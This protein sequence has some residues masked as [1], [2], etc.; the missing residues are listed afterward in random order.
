MRGKLLKNRFLILCTIL[1]LIGYTQ[2]NQGDCEGSIVICGDTSVDVI[3]SSGDILDFNDPDNSLGCHLTDEASSTWLY[4]RFSDTMPINSILEFIISPYEG[5]EVDYDFAIFAADTPCDSLGEPVRCS[6]SWAFANSGCGFCPITGLGMGETDLSEDPF[7]NGF[8]APLEVQPGQ[9][10]YLYINEFYDAGSGSMSNGFDI[11]FGGS[12]ADYFDCG[13][14]PNCDEVVVNAGA[15]ATVCSGDVP[16]QLIGTA[17][18]TTGFETFTW[19]GTNGEEAFLDDPNIPQP[20]ITF[21]AGFSGTITYILEVALGDCIHLDTIELTVLETPV[22]QAPADTTF[23]QGDSVTLNAGAGF[24]SYTWSTGSP[25]SSITVDSEGTYYITV[26]GAGGNCTI[27]DS[28]IVS[29]VPPPSP[30]ISGPTELCPGDTI[31]LDGGGGYAQY[32]WNG[33]P[34][35]QTLEVNAPGTYTLEVTDSTGCTGQTSVD[36]TFLPQPSVTISGPVG[37][38]PGDDGLL[39]AGAGYATYMWSNDSTTQ[40]IEI[41]APG[42]YSVT[43]SNSSGCTDV[44]SIEVEAYQNPNPEIIGDT[45]LCFGA[46]ALLNSA[47]AHDTYFWSTNSDAPVILID[48]GGTYTLTV[49][50]A[51]GCLGSDTIDIIYNDSLALDINVLQNETLCTGD[52]IFLQASTGFSSYL[53]EDGTVGPILPVTSGGTYTVTVTDEVGCTAVDSISINENPLPDPALNGPGGLC[54]GGNDTLEVALFDQ[55]IWQ[56]GS[57]E[58]QLPI[59]MPGTYTVTVTDGNGCSTT[60]TLEVIAYT[61]PDPMIS[62][63][64]SLCEGTSTLLTLVQPYPAYNWSTSDAGPAILIN[65]AGD[66]S[67]TV[68]NAEGC[69]AADTI[70]V[71]EIPSPSLDLAEE[72]FFCLGDSLSIGPS[73]NYA[74]YNWNT[75]DTT[76]NITINN[77]GIYSLTVTSVNGCAAIDSIS[78]IAN[79]LPDAGLEAQYGFCAGE[80]VTIDANPGLNAYEWSEPNVGESL[81]VNTSGT[82]SLT[83]TDANGCMSVDTF[84]VVENALPLPAID[85]DSTLCLG[86]T[87]LLSPGTGFAAYEWQD[88]SNNPEFEVT[89]AGTYSVTA[90]DANGCSGADSITV[91]TLDLPELAVDTLRSFCENDSLTLS[92]DPGY[93]DYDWSNGSNLPDITIFD[94]GQYEVTVTDDN[95][96]QGTAIIDVT[97]NTLPNPTLDGALYFCF[98]DSTTI[99]I[100]G[101]DIADYEWSTGAMSDTETFSQAGLYTV[102]VTDTNGCENLLDVQIDAQPEIIP[103]VDGTALICEG[104]T[105]TLSTDAGFA[106]YNWSTGAN[107]NN[108]PADT[109]GTYTVTVTDGLGCTGQGSFTLS[110]QPLPETMLSDSAYLCEDGISTLSANPGIASYLWN[111]SDTTSTIEVDQSGIYILTA[112][113]SVG[114]SRVD[115][116][117]VADID[118]PAPFIDG[119]LSICPGDTNQ[120]AVE[121]VY[122][123]YAWSTA[124]TASTIDVT[125]A[126]FYQVSVTSVGGCVATSNIFVVSADSVEVEIAGAN[127][128]CQGDTIT[129]TTDNYISYEWSGG[130]IDPALQV[131]STG[132]YSL[133]VTNF[134]GCTASDTVVVNALSLPNPG[135]PDTLG[136]C[137]NESITISGQGGFASYQ[138]QDNSQADSLVAS[139]GG[140]YSLTVTDNNGCEGT[141]STLAYVQ[142]APTPNI[143]GN[144]TFCPEDSITLEVDSQWPNISWSTG[145]TL[146]A[147]TITQQDIYTVTVMDELGCTG[148]AS[149]QV[150]TFAVTAPAIMA[151]AGLCP[152]TNVILEGEAGYVSYEWNTGDNGPQISVDSAGWY[153]L[154]AEDANGC[155]STASWEIIAYPAPQVE[156]LGADSICQGEIADFSASNNFSDYE[157]STSEQSANIE[158]SVAGTYALTVT[159]DNNCQ[160]SDTIALTVVSLPE[161]EISGQNEICEGDITTLSTTEP[162][163]NYTWSGGSSAPTLEAD[164]A[165]TY[166]LTVANAFGCLGSNTFYLSILPLPEPEIIGP[167][168]L[169]EGSM[170]ELEANMMFDSLWWST[171]ETTLGIEIDTAGSYVLYAQTAAGCVASDTVLISTLTQPEVNIQGDTLICDGEVTELE[172]S[173]DGAALEW[174]TGSDAATIEV[175]T[176]GTITVTATAANGCTATASVDV[177]VSSLPNIDA[178]EDKAL[179]CNLSEVTIGPDGAPQPHMLYE[180]EGPGID[181]NNRLDIQPVVDLEGLYSLIATDTITG[182]IALPDTVLVEDLSYEP[183]AIISL[184][185]TLDCSTPT[186]TL[187]GNGST[188]GPNIVYQWYGPDNMPISSANGLEATAESAGQYTLIVADTLLGCQ[189]DAMQ[190]VESNFDYP[191]VNIAPA[192]EL[193]C[194]V[195]SVILSATASAPSG[196]L[197]LQWLDEVPLP[198]PGATETSYETQDAGWFYLLA[199]DLATGCQSIDSVL[200]LENIEVPTAEAGDD[201]EIDCLSNSAVLDGT[202]SSQGS[203]FEYEWSSEN[204]SY[205]TGTLQPEVEQGGIYTLMVTNTETGCSNTDEVIVEISEAFLAGMETQI[206]DPLCAGD[207][208]GLIAVQN[209]IGG[210]PPF[211]YSLNDAPFS[212]QQSFPALG[213]GSYTLTIED[214][215]GC[216]TSQSFLLA[217]GDTV[218]VELG[219]NIEIPL[220]QT[221]EL[222]AQTSVFPGAIEQVIWAPNDTTGCTDCVTFVDTPVQSQLY[223]ATVVDSNGCT[224]MDIIQVFVNKDR[225]VYIPTAFSPNVDGANDIFMI[226]A[227]DDVVEIHNF[228]IYDRWGN[229]LFEVQNFPPNDPK[230]GWDGWF[231]GKLLDPAVFV[232]FAEIEFKDGI[233]EVFKGEVILVR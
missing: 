152:Q 178:G 233:T 156:I 92:A 163:A 113:D 87:T 176:A 183:E 151:P 105:T 7:G 150:D 181:V 79:P 212:S 139:Q 24:D 20:G 109:A 53:W 188:T 54:P 69:Q 190:M 4:F 60:D 202:A 78:A 84:E 13:V 122:E 195:D 33:A 159:D 185:D 48:T 36:I 173:T 129:L 224:G 128:F 203:Q 118:V 112:T 52:T 65:T 141:D 111:T 25:D 205:F 101:G 175:S 32:I 127:D 140:I 130:T 64:D 68:T 229:Q 29:E 177:S 49:T 21:P 50:N 18:Y 138:W 168:T 83:V 19:T 125:E 6:Y 211:L 81:E 38:C 11:T 169:C 126:G 57:N 228:Q 96:C 209:V 5:G 39:D 31:T 103:P 161:P 93:V 99:T 86:D 89:T 133:T 27:I 26:T 58:L 134:Q 230:Y 77:P 157:W 91:S 137:E 189:S 232:Y 114:C 120:L 136:I 196:L 123:T 75:T 158:A 225:Q 119:D 146:S 62:G 207:E 9:G 171:N 23:C 218:L 220:G 56:D 15:D 201:Q 82:Y 221:I 63:S 55:V 34:G 47:F 231:R 61:P 46:S 217:E 208:N 192:D 80:S 66:Y 222:Y 67:V 72:A 131:F 198:I 42:N 132:T 106:N 165:G 164:T 197:G 174:S 108:T 193:T 30:I 206:T 160:A 182:C 71:T 1:P 148:D 227:G 70:S 116:I 121:E 37:L 155:I 142:P 59:D 135:L 184:N 88:G 214:V 216:T 147:I 97:E 149:L 166:T 153:E 76:Q 170:A 179:D 226:Y 22:F 41:D 144:N 219:D 223:T 100:L 162:Y 85:G 102:A 213:A 154:T 210:T 3:D 12:A 186:V 204:G 107:G 73:T 143:V 43:V 145:D 117:L 191:T 44:A 40:T 200:V 16:Y 2:Q 51:E 74:A 187:S 45:L 167:N 14:N 90:T 194:A 199:T 8:V 95:G 35:N 104:A 28:V 98:E 17:T 110:V 10:F 172:A 94:G 215:M 180:W 124:D 115:S